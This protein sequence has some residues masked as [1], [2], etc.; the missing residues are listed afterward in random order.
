MVATLSLRNMGPTLHIR[1]PLRLSKEIQPEH[2]C[3]STCASRLVK[4]HTALTLGSVGSVALLINFAPALKQTRNGFVKS[5]QTMTNASI[6]RETREVS[7]SIVGCAALLQCLWP[8]CSDFDELPFYLQNPAA[9]VLL[10]TICGST[11]M[12]LGYFIAPLLFN[13]LQTIILAVWHPISGLVQDV[14]AFLKR[15]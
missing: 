9:F 15:I 5:F 2:H 12:Q 10:T 3:L 6:P 13:P 4:N 8:F 14:L 11:G 7:A 1:P